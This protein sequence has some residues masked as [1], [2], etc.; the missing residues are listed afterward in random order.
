[1]IARIFLS[2]LPETR[3]YFKTEQQVVRFFE[4]DGKRDVGRAGIEHGQFADD[5]SITAF[6]KER[7]IVAL[8]HSESYQSGT[9]SVDLLLNFF[10]SGR[11]EGIPGF[12]PQEG[13]VGILFYRIFEK[14][15]FIFVFVLSRFH[16]GNYK[17]P[18]PLV[19][20]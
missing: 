4:L 10:I 8:L 7:H 11:F 14:V 12:F 18:L 3:I 15:L 9:G 20:S 2:W 1:M 5:P 6:R 13:I 19:H 17:P 16:P